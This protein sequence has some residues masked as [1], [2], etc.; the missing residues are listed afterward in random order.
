MTQFETLELICVDVHCLVILKREVGW[1]ASSYYFCSEAF[2]L[3]A[4]LLA[5]KKAESSVRLKVG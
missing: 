4:K 2:W 5:S 1:G 3:D